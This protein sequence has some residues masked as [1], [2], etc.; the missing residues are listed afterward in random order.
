MGRSPDALR[1]VVLRVL[2]EVAPEA[3]LARLQPISPRIAVPQ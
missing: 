1:A 3:D 2:A